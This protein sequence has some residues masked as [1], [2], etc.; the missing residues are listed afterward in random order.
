[1]Y[2]GKYMYI[3]CFGMKE[4]IIDVNVNFI[5]SIFNIFCN[6]KWDIEYVIFNVCFF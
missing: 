6:K 3:F 2:F 1:M 5:Y 4:C